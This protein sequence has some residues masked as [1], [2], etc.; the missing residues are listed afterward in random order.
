M[1]EPTMKLILEVV[2][3]NPGAITVIKK[4]EWY[5][6]WFEMIRH[7]HKHGPKGGELW[8]L[9]KD[10][11]HQDID[12]LARDLEARMAKE[13]ETAHFF[14]HYPTKPPKYGK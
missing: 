6:L 9:Y 3:G 8:A 5:R 14:E 13:K 2:Q 11:H 7:L 1:D 4:L 10:V 12:R